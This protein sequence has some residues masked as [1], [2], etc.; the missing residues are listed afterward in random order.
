M[1]QSS[2][3]QP[4]AR[5]AGLA[6]TVQAIV[7]NTTL[8]VL[9]ALFALAAYRS[10][11]GS[12]HAQMLLLAI[13][14]AVIVG[15]VVIR[16]RSAETSRSLRDW[17]VALVGTAAPLLQRPDTPLHPALEPLGIAIQVLGAG[18]SVLATVSLG[19][20]F[21]IVA[22]NR[23]VRTGGL[24][25]FVRHPLYG[26]YLIGYLGFLLGNTAPANLLLVATTV[27]CQHQ[28][29]VAE[30]RVLARDPAYRAYMARVR[31]RFFPYIF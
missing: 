22:A 26:S 3:T 19:R 30:E 14:E 7:G 29:S 17:G 2:T 4:L 10:W 1:A 18:L 31:Y 28:R 6:P 23:G 16:R 25:R 24:Y 11:Q 20:S 9:F 15:L 27:L 8:G 21:G 5:G 12:G 13:Q